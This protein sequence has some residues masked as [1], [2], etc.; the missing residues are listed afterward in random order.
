M[1][2]LL[3][4]R[5]NV[6]RLEAEVK[7]F[8]ESSINL[9]DEV[10]GLQTEIQKFKSYARSPAL[11]N[12][13]DGLFT[14]RL[15]SHPVTKPLPEVRL[16]SSPAEDNPQRTLAAERLIA[17]YHNAIADEQK[18]PL[19]RE[20]EDL[21]T[22]LIRTEL[23]DLMSMIEAGDA[24]GLADFLMHFG[25]SFVWFGGITTCI[26]GY[27]Q[28]LDPQHVAL[29]YLDKLICVGE[30]LGLIGFEFPETTS[31]GT[32]L[33]ADINDLIEKIEGAL[34]I[35]IT[36]PMGAIHTDGLETA[37]GLFH[38]RHIN[39]LYGGIRVREL[40]E[41]VGPCCEFGGGLGMTAMYARRLGVTDYTMLDLP[42]TCLL[43]GHYLL[44][45]VGLDSVRLYGEEAD[46][47]TIKI[48]PYWEC[49]NLPE[50]HYA[51]A[52]NQDS[53]PEI[54]DNLIEEYLVQIK[55]MTKD[56]FLSI[57]H[58]GFDP[59]TVNNF[60]KRAKGY[61]KVSRSKY[62]LREGYVEEL[63]RIQ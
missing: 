43:A 1:S 46:P 9:R 16:G 17:A 33:H 34:E 3:D 52:V 50:K 48:L 12:S 25:E 28:K 26:D 24:K 20:G 56:Y 19:A 7:K 32:N 53:F 15:L 39:G 47:G 63:F 38:Y 30:Y 57:N 13:P 45:S 2:E 49:L 61:K 6:A 22:G 40:N 44:H 10:I 29:T 51:L 14:Q 58:E 37:K 5:N 18:S 8:K 23:P 60:A 35:S 4:L 55:R 62:W 42:I 41:D 11:N 27:T 31:W 36:P 21:W 59:K 54:A